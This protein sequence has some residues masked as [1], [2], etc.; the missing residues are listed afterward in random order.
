MNIRRESYD[1]IAQRYERARP[2]YPPALFADIV[3]YAHLE[4]DARL[5]EIGCGSGQASLP[6]AER[7]YTIDCVEIGARLA[8]IAREKLS[9]YPKVAVINADFETAELPARHYDLLY[10]ATAFHWI[11]PAIR[12]TKAHELL[13][14]AGTLALFWLR[15]ALTA[16][17]RAAEI[18]LQEIYRR[19]APDLAR[20]YTPPPRPNAVR[21]EYETLIPASGFFD[22]LAIRKHYVVTEYRAEAYIDLLGTFSDHIALPADKQSQLFNEVGE[23]IDK[24]FAGVIQRET[25]ALL[26]LA[27]RSSHRRNRAK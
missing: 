4:A 24:D 20:D 13:K 19:V 5:L 10:S 18:A 3:K 9:P 26:Y 14:P 2:T 23:L 8:A 11:E 16:K 15:P 21:T 17:S 12:F 25:V 27:R 22:A 6:L 7:G 1:P